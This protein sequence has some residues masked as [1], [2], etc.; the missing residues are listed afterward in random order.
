LLLYVAT[1]VLK[2]SERQ[3]WKMSPR[4]LNALV[5]VHIKMNN[6]DEDEDSPEKT[7]HGFIDQV[8]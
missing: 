5:K 1:V 6:S 3:F 4:K 7:K 8:F 2:R